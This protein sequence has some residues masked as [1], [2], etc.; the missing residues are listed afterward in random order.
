MPY[1]SLG[2]AIQGIEKF[3]FLTLKCFTEAIIVE[4]DVCYVFDPHSRNRDG[5]VEVD[6]KAV[7]T[8]HSSFENLIQFLEKLA[9]R[10]ANADGE[11]LAFEVTHVD[12]AESTGSGICSNESEDFDGFSDISFKRERMRK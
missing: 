3:A 2:E 12:I 10:L 9:F 6:G 1:V 5:L 11:S 4:N 8:S 7:L